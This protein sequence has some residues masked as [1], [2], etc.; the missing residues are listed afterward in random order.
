MSE[1]DLW[2]RTQERFS[3]AWSAK[4]GECSVPE[5]RDKIRAALQ[6]RKGKGWIWQQST[7][8]VRCAQDDFDNLVN[9]AS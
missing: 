2:N 6:W 1:G 9:V 5:V 8:V 4:P 3:K 7:A